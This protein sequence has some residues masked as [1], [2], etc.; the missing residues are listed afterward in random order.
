[1]FVRLYYVVVCTGISF[2]FMDKEYSIVWLNQ[3]LFIHP[4]VD[5]HWN[6]FH[7]LSIMSYAAMNISVKAFVGAYIFI[8]AGYILSSGNAGSNG[9]S[10]F[11][12]HTFSNVAIFSFYFKAEKKIYQITASLLV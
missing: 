9:T 11:N 7:L 10:M 2:L 6:L 5:T 4:S 12:F 8:P 3:I 1:M